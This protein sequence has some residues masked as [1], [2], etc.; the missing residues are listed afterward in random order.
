MH[1]LREKLEHPLFPLDFLVN[2]SHAPQRL[3]D[4]RD[5]RAGIVQCVKIADKCLFVGV[6]VDHVEIERGFHADF[7]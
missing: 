6:I 5:I 3:Y 4:M 2:E 1:R 7:P